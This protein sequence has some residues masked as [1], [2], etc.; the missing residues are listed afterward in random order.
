MKKHIVL[1]A[2]VVSLIGTGIVG[3]THTFAQGV[4]DQRATL[5]QKLAEKFGLNKNEV[6]A[7]FDEH[8]KEMVGKMRTNMEER[9]SQ[10]VTEGKITDAQKTLILNKI[11]ELQA[12][13]ESERESLKDLTPEERKAAMERKHIELQAW[14]KEN[15][16]PEDV[17][18]F[19]MKFNGGP[20]KQGNGMFRHRIVTE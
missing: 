9:L 2:L 3:V 20:G 12:S 10:A 17:L 15:N 4:D 19:K 16:I 18:L 5:V 14:A 7:V 8:H 1:A 6:Q 13:H 11:A